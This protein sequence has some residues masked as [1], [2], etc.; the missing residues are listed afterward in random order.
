VPYEGAMLNSCTRPTKL[1]CLASM[2][3]VGVL[4]CAVGQRYTAAAL[5]AAERTAVV[6]TIER[7]SRQRPDSTARSVD[8]DELA[9]RGRAALPAASRGR[10]APD[11]SIV[12]EGRI[13]GSSSNEELAEMCRWNR[14]VRE[15]RLSTQDETL[16]HQIHVISR[17]AAYE[18]MSISE[19]IH[20]KDGRTT[21]RP[22]VITRI[23][24]RGPDGWMRAHVHESW[25]AGE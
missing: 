10:S 15:A 8:C 9:R 21:V 4:G 16:D 19:T 17:D 5:T 11:F 20:W 12:S 7:L 13:F 2:A 1:T 18:L 22:M 25:P 3:A 23:W 14:S 6:D 24:S